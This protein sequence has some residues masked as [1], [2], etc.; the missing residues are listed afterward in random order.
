[1]FTS[2]LKKHPRP[3]TSRRFDLEPLRHNYLLGDDQP[4]F[5]ILNWNQDSVR[6]AAGLHRD[7]AAGR[8]GA[9]RSRHELGS[10]RARK[11]VRVRNRG[12]RVPLPMLARS[13]DLVPSLNHAHRVTTAHPVRREDAVQ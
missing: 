12:V 6:L 1:M 10:D 11:A 3:G 7:V 8:R 13:Q 9:A 4:A 2:L 5:D